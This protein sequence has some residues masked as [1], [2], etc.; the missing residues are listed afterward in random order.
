[1][2]HDLVDVLRRILPGIGWSPT[3][4]PP[5]RSASPPVRAPAIPCGGGAPPPRGWTGRSV[6]ARGWRDSR[7]TPMW[8]STPEPGSSSSTSVATSCGPRWPWTDSPRAPMDSSPTRLPHPRRD[9]ATHLLRDPLELIEKPDAL[10]PRPGFTCSGSMASWPPAPDSA[11][12]SSLS[13]AASLST[14][15]G[16]RGRAILHRGPAR[17]ACAA[18]STRDRQGAGRQW[19]R[20]HVGV[21]GRAP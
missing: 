15:V 14:V 17:V 20:V 9:G 7:S 11:P 3:P 18:R 12:K 2:L 19:L 5:S 1:M 8:P 13:P 16:R 10:L 21:L 6:V 4:P